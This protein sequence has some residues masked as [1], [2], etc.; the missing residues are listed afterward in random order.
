MKPSEPSGE[1]PATKL[2]AGSRTVYAS[3]WMRLREDAIVRT[4]GSQGRFAVVSRSD[5][6]VVH[7]VTPQGIVLTDQYRYAADLWSAELPQGGIEPGESPL[8]AALRE[9][10][11]ETGW[12]GF[13]AGVV[14]GR[15]YE[16]A[17][18]A[19]QH[20]TVVSLRA[21]VRADAAPE[22][23][24]AGLTSRTVLPQDFDRMI[25]SGE[26]ADAAT[27]AAVALVRLAD[28]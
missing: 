10:R 13:G 2:P 28:G 19:T 20:F 4:D 14:G 5:F 7:C 24:E 26:I 15:V 6:V 18:W 27:L 22:R 23:E 17:D 9:L 11:E 3:P 16:A 25:R 1:R 21:E 12:I 8:D